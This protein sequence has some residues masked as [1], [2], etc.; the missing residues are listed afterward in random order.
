[1]IPPQASHRAPLGWAP[2]SSQHTLSFTWG[3]SL[4]SRLGEETVQIYDL[5]WICRRV[6]RSAISPRV[7]I[8]LG[9]KNLSLALS[10]GSNQCW[11]QHIL[12]V[13]CTT[14]GSWCCL[15]PSL[16]R[17]FK[18]P[19]CLTRRR[20]LVWCPRLSPLESAQPFYGGN[21]DT[22]PS[23]SPKCEST[24]KNEKMKIHPQWGLRGFWKPRI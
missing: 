5:Y 7:L 10:F 20:R 12:C 17:L 21:S 13:V 24:I 6:K 14:L 8:F 23:A 2:F 16:L 11:I 1:M 19:P 18:T 4:E 3:Y 15:T 9:T 22:Y